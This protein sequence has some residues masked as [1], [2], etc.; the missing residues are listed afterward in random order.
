MATDCHIDRTNEEQR[1]STSLPQVPD[2]AQPGS[3]SQ[4]A[5]ELFEERLFSATRPMLR[6]MLCEGTRRHA[7]APLLTGIASEAN[8][9]TG[10]ESRA[11]AREPTG[12][13]I[14]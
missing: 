4:G 9:R 5:Y 6:G 7:G 3:A 2:S 1:W 8:G 12:E 10:P 13:R 14:T 11:P